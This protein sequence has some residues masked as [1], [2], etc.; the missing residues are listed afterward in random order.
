LLYERSK[1]KHCIG[2]YFNFKRS[3]K[4]AQRKKRHQLNT[5]TD[6]MVCAVMEETPLNR[7]PIMSAGEIDYR[8][9]DALLKIFQKK[10]AG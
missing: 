4:K 9:I 6:R 8:M 7:L 5:A 10:K 1:K 3:D 2:A